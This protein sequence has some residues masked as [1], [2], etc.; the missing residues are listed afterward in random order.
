MPT[1]VILMSLNIFAYDW[2]SE[3]VLWMDVSLLVPWI[4]IGFE[5]FV[6]SFFIIQEESVPLLWQTENVH[7]YVCLM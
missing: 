7:A 5:S 2:Q 3:L 1:Y 6:R 4:V